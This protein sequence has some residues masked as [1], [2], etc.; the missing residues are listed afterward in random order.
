MDSMTTS[1]SAVRAARVFAVSFALAFAPSVVAQTVD[2]V[3]VAYPS[4]KCGSCAAWNEPRS[5]FKIFGNTYYVGTAG[6][7]SILITSANGDVLIDGA[8]PL[9]APLIEANIRALGFRVEDV[10]LILNS[11]AHYDHAGGIAA[12]QRATGA[13]VAALPWSAEVLERGESDNRDPQ[14]GV[15]NPFPPVRDVQRIQD[16]ETLRVGSLALTAHLTAGHTPSGTS[17]TWQSCEQGRCVNILYADS[18][19]PVS[20]DSF[21]FTHNP[22]YPTAEAD[23]ARGLSVLEQLPC[24]ILLTPH[25]GVSSFFDRVAA[26]DSGSAS[27]LIDPALCKRFVDLARRDVTARMTRERAVRDS[28]R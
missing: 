17:W 24:E 13:R 12:I 1:R 9:S 4:V 3:R 21:Y 26:R 11:H 7:S 27:A 14:F 15:V 16:G 28:E 18:Q 2:T 23:F 5:P 6:L 20:A 22:T 10:R 19:S 8:L 25:P